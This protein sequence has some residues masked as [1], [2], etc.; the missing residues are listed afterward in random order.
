MLNNNVAILFEHMVNWSI[1]TILYSFAIAD[2][3]EDEWS[4]Y[5]PVQQARSWGS[6]RA[7]VMGK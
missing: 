4:Q 3:V 1:L 2:S 6:T 7:E 5:V